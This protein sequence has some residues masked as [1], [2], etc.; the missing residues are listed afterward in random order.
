MFNHVHV[1]YMRYAH[2]ITE[3]REI[4]WGP[5]TVHQIWH[6]R[7][8]KQSEPQCFRWTTYA[9]R[10]LGKRRKMKE[11]DGRWWKMMEDDGRWWKMMED[12]GR[13]WKMME[14]DGKW[15]KMMEDDGRWWKMMEDDGRWW[16]MMEDDGRWWKMMED[17]GRWWKML[18]WIP[19]NTCQP[20]KSSK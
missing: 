6:S 19:V 4:R 14:D 18:P 5:G 17:D 9:P 12:D 10:V 16:K 8:D 1:N 13:W 15:W 11:D 7:H 2:P 3:M 20:V